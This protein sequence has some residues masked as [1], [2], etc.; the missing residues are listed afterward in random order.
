MKEWSRLLVIDSALNKHLSKN[1]NIFSKTYMTKHNRNKDLNNISTSKALVPYGSNLS[2]TVG[3]P[4]FT[5]LERKSILIPNN[6]LFFLLELFF[7][8][9]I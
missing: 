8:M 7:Q 9:P 5:A 4:R 2:S 3:S 6:L 1:S